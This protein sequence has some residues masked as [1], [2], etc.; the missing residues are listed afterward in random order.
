MLRDRRSDPE[1]GEAAPQMENHKWYLT[2]EV[3]FTVFSSR[4]SDHQR[5]DIGAWLL[6]TQKPDTFRKGKLVF[7]NMTVKISLVDCTALEF[8]LLLD[9]LSIG[10]D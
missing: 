7:H 4:L 8:H 10:P 1:V 9:I 3:P 5:W 6:A 2:L